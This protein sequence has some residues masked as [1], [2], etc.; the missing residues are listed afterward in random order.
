MLILI[1]YNII[2][3]PGSLLYAPGS[4]LYVSVLQ[5]RVIRG[6]L[7]AVHE[8]YSLLTCDTVCIGH[9]AG[10]TI[11]GQATTLKLATRVPS[12]RRKHIQTIQNVEAV[13]SSTM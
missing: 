12:K 6:P 11:H 4:L 2:Y 9:S 13:P 1:K 7:T 8:N 10:E 5:A 3:A